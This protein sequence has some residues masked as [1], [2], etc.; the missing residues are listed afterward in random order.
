[1][2]IPHAPVAL[3]MAAALPVPQSLLERPR[4]AVQVPV[5]R[6]PVT[7]VTCEFCGVTGLSSAIPDIGRG[8]RCADT[9]ACA[10]RWGNRE[11]AARFAPVAEGPAEAAAA[12]AHPYPVP[13][14]VAE[15]ERDPEEDAPAGRAVADDEPAPAADPVAV[16]RAL[17]EKQDAAEEPDATKVIAVDKAETEAMPAVTEDGGDGDE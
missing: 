12:E 1:V 6:E 11:A 5:R 15:P 17:A 16:L 3:E 13:A 9:D 2:D 14:P 8:H 7:E 10:G 4:R